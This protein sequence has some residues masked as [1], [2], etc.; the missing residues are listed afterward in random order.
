MRA[1]RIPTINSFLLTTRK[2]HRAAV[3]LIQA[4][5]IPTDKSSPS[6]ISRVL[7]TFGPSDKSEYVVTSFQVSLDMRCLVRE[8][9]VKGG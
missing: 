5:E 2:P 4:F 3:P 8:R 6:D 9:S 7:F 1:C